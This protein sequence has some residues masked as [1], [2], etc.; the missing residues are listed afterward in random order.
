MTDLVVLS[1][2]QGSGKSSFYEARF[3]ATHTHVSKDRFR[4]HRDKGRRQRELVEEAAREG[5]SVVV[6]NT[7]PTRVDREGLVAL[8][9]RLGLRPVLYWF[10]PNVGRSIAWNERRDGTPR[11][12]KV[13]ILATM[14]RLEPPSADEGFAAVYEVARPEG[15]FL[16][17]Q[18]SDLAASRGA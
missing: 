18:R 8:A 7:S 11:V 5:R 16:V 1:G 4:N 10:P 15:A 9:R 13:A 17:T 3:S 12:P 6:D 14:R 2:L